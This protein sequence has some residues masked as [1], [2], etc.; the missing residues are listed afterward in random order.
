MRRPARFLAL[1]LAVG[2]ALI[3]QS[4]QPSTAVPSAA[5]QSIRRLDGSHISIRE[6]SATAR[7]ILDENHVTGAQIA[8]L[9]DGRPVWAEAFGYR[10]LEHV[11][12]MTPTTTTWAASIT[13]GLFATFV[14][15]LSQEKQ[16]D[17]NMPVTEL[18]D[19]PLSSYPEYKDSAS[20]IVHDPRFAHVTPRTLLSHTSGL[21]N[22]AAY[23]PDKKLHLHFD[24]G[25]R[26]AYSG[27][28]L[29][30]LQFIIEQREHQPLDKLMQDSLFNPLHMVRTSMVWNPA[31]TGYVA[32]R[33][34]E[35]GKFIS[36]TMRDHARAAGSMTTSSQ[37]LSLFLMFLLYEP[38]HK[39]HFSSKTRPPSLPDPIWPLLWPGTLR[40]MLSPVIRIDAKQQF[41]T[42]DQTKS[43]EG[44]A[45]GLA[46]G[47]G[48]GLLTRTKFGPAFFKEGHGD[49]A[50]NYMICFTKHRDCMIILTNSDNGELA[51]R[52]LLEGLLGDTVTPWTWEGYTREGILASREKH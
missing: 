21:A 50:Q 27:E 31:F 39:G 30:L 43:T 28:G 2:P 47:L 19:K 23:E 1:S 32:D 42:L 52:P 44:P 24:P 36:H 6:A 38:P 46:Y 16:L 34:D 37:D 45:V 13:K 5:P 14:M 7:R 10:E 15:K 48:W 4:P 40:T 26:F 12:P 22:F 29:N 51:F 17:L 9:N 18:L 25:T 49:G 41:P 20:E 8:I 11:L 35:N 3:A 33:Y